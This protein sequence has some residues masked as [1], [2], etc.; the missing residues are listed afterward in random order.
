MANEIHDLESCA[1]VQK[2][3]D[4]LICRKFIARYPIQSNNSVYTS[5][6]RTKLL[7][8]CLVIP[9]LGQSHRPF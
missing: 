2:H 4:S 9:I 7:A 8:G 1:S 5:N 3:L 6:C